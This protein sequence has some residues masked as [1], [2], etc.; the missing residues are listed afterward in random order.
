LGEAIAA[1]RL[2]ESAARNVLLIRINE[3]H[4]L[5]E[6]PRLGNGFCFQFHRRRS[7]RSRLS[8]KMQ[9][10]GT[11]LLNETAANRGVRGQKPSLPKVT[12]AALIDGAGKTMFH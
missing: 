3:C 6:S 1:A 9:L 2:T 7:G 5:P 8:I 12:G 11:P 10:F 4:C